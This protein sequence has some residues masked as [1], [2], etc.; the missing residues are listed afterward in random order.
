M[1]KQSGGGWGILAAIV[2]VALVTA[3]LS[4]PAAAGN[5]TAM[6]QTFAGIL[7]SAI[8]IGGS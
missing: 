3:V 4:K 7:R 1:A 8:N 2:A 5:I 6:G